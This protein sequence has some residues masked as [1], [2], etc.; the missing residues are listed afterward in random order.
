MTPD[1]INLII[2]TF[3]NKETVDDFS[4]AVSYEDLEAKKCTLAAGRYF[5]VKLE[6]I[7]ITE[8]EYTTT[9]N[10]IKLDLL[11][12]FEKNRIYEDLIKECLERLKYEQDK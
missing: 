2:E 5:D 1:E 6:R 9:I 8:E 7:D 10:S 3:N 11:A 12:H 4:V